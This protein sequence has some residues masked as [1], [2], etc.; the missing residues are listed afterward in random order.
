[1]V[2]CIF[3]IVTILPVEMIGCR[4]RGLIAVAVAMASGIA[5]I[6]AAVKA[7]IGRIRR[8]ANSSLWMISAIILALPAVYIVFIAV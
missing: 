1:M 2:T 7:I 8:D 3:F 6:S 5:G 4:N